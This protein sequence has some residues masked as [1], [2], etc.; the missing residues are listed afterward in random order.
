VGARASTGVWA[1]WLVAAAVI[2]PL[3][4]MARPTDGDVRLE[5]ALWTL[6]GVTY[7][8]F[9]GSFI[10]LLRYIDFDGRSWVYLTVLSTFAVDTGSYFTGRAI[11]R[12]KLAPRISPKKTVE[13]LVGGYMA[14]FGAVV[15]LGYLF[16][17]GV[18]PAKMSL[19]GL[20][21][22]GVA[23]VGD[24]AESAIKRLAGIKDASELIPGHGGV[25][26]RLDSILFTFALVYL[27]TQWVV[28]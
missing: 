3:A 19:L 11:G 8:G 16:D 17:L 1:A 6:A 10:V 20:L 2:A 23:A 9:L 7:V 25:L 4:A 15:L 27:F 24:L 22:P 21:L 18:A 13:G 26:D 28:Y 12:H 5:D 14:G